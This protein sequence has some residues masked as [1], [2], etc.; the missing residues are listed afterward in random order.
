MDEA[1]E[2]Q[3]DRSMDRMIAVGW[4]L[5]ALL[6]FVMLGT[7]AMVTLDALERGPKDCGSIVLKECL[8][9]EDIGRI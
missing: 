6:G 9:G 2:Q 7:A 3:R 4:L 5:I 1:N 8:T